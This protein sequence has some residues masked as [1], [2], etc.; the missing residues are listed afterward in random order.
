MGT[1]VRG[2]SA[3]AH[4]A[5][6][7]ATPAAPRRGRGRCCVRILRRA[8]ALLAHR[9]LDALIRFRFGRH[10]GV[11]GRLLALA[12]RGFSVGPHD[13]E[14]RTAARHLLLWI[15]EPAEHPRRLGSKGRVVVGPRAGPPGRVDNLAGQRRIVRICGRRRRDGAF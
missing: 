8:K 11:R 2:G 3:D 10:R 15:V 6:S 13:R 7:A 5:R 4:A 1:A 12:P 14:G 9:R